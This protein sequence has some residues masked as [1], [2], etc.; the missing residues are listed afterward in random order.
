MPRKNEEKP[1]FQPSILDWQ[2]QAEKA[3][4]QIFQF[5]PGTPIWRGSRGMVYAEKAFLVEKINGK[6]A[7][8]SAFKLLADTLVFRQRGWEPKSYFYLQIDDQVGLAVSK[9]EYRPKK[10]KQMFQ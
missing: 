2:K 9:T 4:R 3:E 6:I 7:G 10:I 8:Y 1:A 5:P